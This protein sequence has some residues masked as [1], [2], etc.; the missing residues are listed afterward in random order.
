M[1]RRQS[2][3]SDTS[4]LV[5]SCRVIGIQT[6]I[7]WRRGAVTTD[8]YAHLAT[9]FIAHYGT[10][11]G[12]IREC[13]AFDQ[14]SRLDGSGRRLQGGRRCR[15]SLG[16]RTRAHRLAEIESLITDAG[17]GLKAWYGIPPVTDAFPDVLAVEKE[18]GPHRAVVCRH[19]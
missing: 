10:M 16:V 1:D 18:A 7:R 14:L 12:A 13:L 15:R 11:R 19:G 17:F 2:D 3:Q 4:V 5:L 6:A 8:P 9:R